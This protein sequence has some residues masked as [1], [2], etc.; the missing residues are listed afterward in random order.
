M[1]KEKTMTNA[2]S[3]LKTRRTNYDDLKKKFEGSNSNS[4]FKKD[5]RFYYPE[6]D[7]EG[8]GYALLRFLP[9]DAAGA[10]FVETFSHRFQGPAGWFIDSC[11]TTVGEDCPVCELN[12]QTVQENGGDFK[13]MAREPQ[14]LVRQRSR[15]RQFVANVYVVRDPAT[16]ENEGKVFLFR[17]GTKIM[18]KIKQAITPEFPGDPQFDPFNPWQGAN[19]ALKIRKVK[20]QT[21]YD[22]SSF[23]DTSALFDEDDAIMALG[24]RVISL[25]EFTDPVTYT[26][27]EDQKAR[28]DRV[29]GASSARPTPP[30]T[31]EETPAPAENRWTPPAETAATE[32]VSE[33]S[34]DSD[35]LEALFNEDI[36]F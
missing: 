5:E 35:D 10:P 27:Y 2:F 16:P 7:Q 17:F 18:D 3:G 15:K 12:R 4:K 20:G 28:L 9:G 1:P 26:S 13:R 25:G 8:N 30:A 6:R 23:N 21:N 24:E 34:S 33:S 36:N 11:R 19:F 32:A 22:A 31:Q 14:D 29:M